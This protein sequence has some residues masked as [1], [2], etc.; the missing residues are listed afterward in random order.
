M[1]ATYVTLDTTASP[2]NYPRLYFRL[3]LGDGESF[4]VDPR[5]EVHAGT[6]EEVLL[7]PAVSTS[8]NGKA[9]VVWQQGDTASGLDLLGRFVMPYWRWIPVVFKD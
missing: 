6:T 2:P 1:Y 3:V 5:L 7:N 8:M 4:V 9:F